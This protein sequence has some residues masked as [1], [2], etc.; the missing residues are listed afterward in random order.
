[1]T[2]ALANGGALA[3]A[4]E[5]HHGVEPALVGTLVEALSLEQ[6][7]AL[8]A[9]VPAIDDCTARTPRNRP[10]PLLKQLQACVRK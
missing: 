10:P 8:T 5:L 1:M 7:L 3:H 9:L 6:S 4:T 2:Q